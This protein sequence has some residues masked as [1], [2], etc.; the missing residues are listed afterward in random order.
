[1]S[2]HQLAA[3]CSWLLMFVLSACSREHASPAPASQQQ[4]TVSAA[5]E[6]SAIKVIKLGQT[7]PYS[8]PASAYSTVGKLHA[9]Y[10]KQLNEAGGIHGRTIE[11]LSLDDAYSPP[12]AIEQVRKLVEQ[13][14]VLAVFQ[15]VGTAA[16]SAVHKY[17]NAQHVPQ[18]FVSSGATKWADPEHFPW[19]I[20]YNP[21][22]QREGRTYAKYILEHVP[23]AKIAVLY[24]NDDFGKDLLKGLRDGLGAQANLI[25]AEA[26]YETSDARIDSQISALKGS[27]ANTFVDITTPRFAALAVRAVYDSGWKPLHFLNNVGASVGTALLPAGLEKAIG[28]L[29]TQY[30]KDPND[31]QWDSD[32][33]MQEFKNFMRTRFPDGD[34]TDSFNPYAYISA[35]VLVQVLEQCGDTLTRENII[36]QAANLKDFAPGLLLPGVVINTS[37]GDYEVFDHV[38][39]ARFDGTHWALL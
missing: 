13:D 25:V 35:Q 27:G 9:A 19:T 33:A 21:T 24:Q 10:F 4:T 16:N 7:M 32:P 11:L 37:Q 1:M 18:L 17:L 2:T 23:H 3:T 22:Y 39:L 28:L 5:A 6:P 31:K 34:V 36:K 38:Q 20:G 29:S 15:S 30:V 12:K 14:H 8:G 26:S